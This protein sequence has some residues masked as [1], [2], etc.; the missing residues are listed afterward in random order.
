LPSGVYELTVEDTNG[1]IVEQEIIIDEPTELILDL[2]E[3]LIIELGDSAQLRPLVNMTVD[4]FI[5]GP[6]SVLDC[7]DCWNQSVKPIQ[8]MEYTL[9]TMTDDGCTDTESIQVIVSKERP[10]FIPSVFSPNGDGENDELRLLGNGID[11]MHLAIYNRWGQKVFETFDQNIAWD[12]T[13][14]GELLPPDSYGFY[15]TARCV[16]QEEFYKQGN[17]TLL[18]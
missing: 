6:T 7:P 4:S 18:K 1:C 8:S 5:W 2:G 14:K 3:N 12:G 16:N 9:T 15:L 13:F 17:I 11:E 10:I